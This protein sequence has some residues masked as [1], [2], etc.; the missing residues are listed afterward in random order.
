MPMHS[1]FWWQS[2]AA[3]VNAFEIALLIS[4]RNKQRLGRSCQAIQ[5]ATA[6]VCASRQTS[7]L[8]VTSQSTWYEEHWHTRTEAAKL[9]S[10]RA[11]RA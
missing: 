1:V 4:R 8:E 10:M 2:P 3:A 6:V 11:S 5:E 9:K 7:L